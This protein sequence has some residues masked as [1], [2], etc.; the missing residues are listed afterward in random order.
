[1]LLLFYRGSLPDG[2]L[3]LVGVVG[4]RNPTGVARS[5]AFQ[6]G[7]ELSQGGIGVVSGLARG[8]DVEAHR[9][10]LEGRAGAVA[11]LGNGLNTVY[12]VKNTHVGLRI[13][14]RGGVL[15]SEYPPDTPPLKHHF[16]ARNRIISGLS[17]SVVVVQAPN[18]SG[19]LITADYALEQGRDLFVHRIGLYGKTGSGSL[20]LANDGAKVIG[21]AE[22]IFREWGWSLRPRKNA[23]GVA[24]PGS[25]KNLARLLER[26]L[27]GEVSL[28]NGVYFASSREESKR[29]LQ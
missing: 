6:M 23:G 8:I 20:R 28:H 21:S 7:F 9:G 18:S 24:L 1:P 19:A 13:I 22:E 16:P 5:S 26:E 14:E 3:P 25:G 29:K 17:R 12:P 15:L 27:D 4:T 11:V 10:C 2:A